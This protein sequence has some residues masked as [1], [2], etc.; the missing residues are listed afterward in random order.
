LPA[1]L[2]NTGTILGPDWILIGNTQASGDDIV[3]TTHGY[4]GHTYQLQFAE[5]VASPSWLDAG[6][7]QPGADAPLTLTHPGGANASNRFYRIS[8]LPLHAE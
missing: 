1:N 4:P 7:P 6:P 3:V 8:V 5:A 2:V